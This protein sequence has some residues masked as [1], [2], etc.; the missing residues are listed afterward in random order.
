MSTAAVSVGL[1]VYN[2]EQFLAIAVESILNQTFSDFELIISDNASTDS[3]EEICRHY[4]RLD[5]R[6]RYDRLPVNQGAAGNYRRV[7]ELSRGRYFKWQAHDDVCLPECISRCFDVFETAP[8]SV[9]S[10]HPQAELIDAQGAVIGMN[11]EF[12]DARHSRPHHRLAHVLRN[13]RTASSVEYGLIRS[14]A[15]RQTRLI[16]PFWASD[17][18]LV[19]ELA[20]LGQLW[21]IPEPLSQIRVHTGGTI[22]KSWRDL[23]AWFDPN[24]TTSANPAYPMMRLGME[25][26]RSANLLP[27]A[28]GDRVLCQATALFV[29]HARE[30]RNIGGAYKRRLKTLLGWNPSDVRG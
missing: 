14:D 9:V 17:Y 10:V 3:T 16:G 4:A 15:L 30:F 13:L 23:A 5:G 24:A 19:A 26:A 22:H 7:F 18:V 27:L 28:I 2:G 8:R 20:M 1:P 29:W 11:D 6:I 25:Y 21:Q 12:L